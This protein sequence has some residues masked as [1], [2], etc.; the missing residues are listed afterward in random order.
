MS[1]KF[2]RK[3]M[4][5]ELLKRTQESDDRKE[6]G[7]YSKYFKDDFELTFAKFGA[8]KEEP[9]IVDIIPFIAGDKMPDFMRVKE[10]KPAYYLDIYVHQNIGGGKAWVV[11][12]AKNYGDDC[13]VCEYINSLVKDGKEYEDYAEIAPKRRCVYNI[14]NMT[15]DKEEK[16]GIQ[17]WESS[18]KYSEKAIQ[19]AA[20][21]P[22]G[23]GSIPFSHPDKEVGQS[24]SFSVDNDTYKTVSGHKLVPR[25][26]DISDDI[27]DKAFQLDQI[28]KILSYKEI[29]KIFE[30]YSD[31]D[32]KETSKS[33]DECSESE[34]DDKSSRRLKENKI[35]DECPEGLNFG[36]DID[37]SDACANC[38]LYDDCAKKAD[39][40]EEQIKKE[41]EKR[42]NARRG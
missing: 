4:K 37:N 20:K 33:K 9:H 34:N 2:D 16:K 19:S 6:G 3:A 7:D 11:C 21:A 1:R 23:G 31:D 5:E 12:P 18:H 28:I 22:R 17:I 14:I 13:P 41:R 10:G 27:L 35:V 38:N 24:I 40:I 26:Y 29:K 32:E 30:K 8:T 36:E 39:E 25:E 15:T 42:R